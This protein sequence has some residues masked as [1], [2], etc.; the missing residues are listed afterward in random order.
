MARK[1][2][3]YP[4]SEPLNGSTPVKVD[5]DN[6]DGNMIIDGQ[7]GG[8]AVLASG[9]L[10]YTET[11]GQ[12]VQSTAASQGQTTFTLKAGGGQP[13]FRL[14]WSSCNGATEWLVHLNPAISYDIT[15]HSGGGNIRL[16]L[17]GMTVTHV[18][19]DTGGGNM[20]VV[21]PDTGAAFQVIA[22]TGAGNVKVQ[23]PGSIAAKILAT[24]GAGKVIVDLRFVKVGKNTY[25]SPD[26]DTAISKVE[27]TLSSGAGNVVVTEHIT[28]RVPA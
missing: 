12:P 9:M 19:A 6:G 16:D 2:H 1:L 23:L 11:Q 28:Q 25:Q 24:S 14:P 4:L 22:K 21:L 26:Y 27:I 17:A 8:E 15:A 3:T 5:I 18:K 20:D 13:W 10:Q 7:T